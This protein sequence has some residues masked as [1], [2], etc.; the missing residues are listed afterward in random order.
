VS[1]KTEAFARIAKEAVQSSLGALAKL[2]GMGGDP[3]LR[4]EER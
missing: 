2:A 1:G 3:E 4:D